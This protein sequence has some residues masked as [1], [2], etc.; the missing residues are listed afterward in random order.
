M[1]S[2]DLVFKVIARDPSGSGLAYAELLGSYTV[3]DNNIYCISLMG[4]AFTGDLRD[5]V[6]NP[7][8]VRK[9]GTGLYKIRVK[10]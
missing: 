10:E 9:V 5:L 3:D 8:I 1:K 6:I 4:D 2:S 7:V